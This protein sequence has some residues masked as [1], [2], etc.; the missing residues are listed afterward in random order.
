[1][2]PKVVDAECTPIQRKGMYRSGGVF[3]VTSRVLI[4]DLLNE[5]RAYFVGLF[6]SK[7]RAQLPPA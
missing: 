7:H 1:M 4:V 5:V 2:H 6:L 3:L